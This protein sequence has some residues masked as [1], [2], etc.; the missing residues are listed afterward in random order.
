M[1]AWRSVSNQRIITRTAAGN[2][3]TTPEEDSENINAVA[4]PEE[5]SP[6]VVCLSKPK[7]ATIVHGATG[8][9]C[10]CV[11]CARELQRRGA[12][13]PICRAPIHIVI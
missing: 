4:P 3:V 10:C 2:P 8:R 11:G 6:C 9:V 5:S 7:D 13:C 1:P 12:C